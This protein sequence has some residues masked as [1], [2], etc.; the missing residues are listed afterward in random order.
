MRKAFDLSVQEI[1]QVLG[2]KKSVTDVTRLAASTL[3]SYGKI[4]MCDI[5]EEVMRIGLKGGG[6][7]MKEIG[8]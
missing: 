1:E 7:P 3:L 8:K 5:Q 4:K 6:K 2:S